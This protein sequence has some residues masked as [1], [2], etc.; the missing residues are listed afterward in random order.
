MCVLVF[1][2][3]EKSTFLCGDERSNVDKNFVVFSSQTHV[4][5]ESGKCQNMND[6]VPLV[7]V[8]NVID[9]MPQ[10]K[11]MLGGVLPNMSNKR[12]RNS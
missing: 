4:L 9:F 5:M 2:L 12:Q 3:G 10:L 6:V 1:V 11:Y 7:Q 8:T